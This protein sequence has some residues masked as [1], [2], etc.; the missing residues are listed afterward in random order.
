MKKLLKTFGYN[1]DMQYY[2]LIGD[3]FINGNF[4]SAIRLFTDMPKRNRIDM[5]KA[6]TVGG[7]ESGISNK[8]LAHL[9]DN[10]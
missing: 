5:L 9:F 8:H 6:A 2:E 1:S 7:W 3:N 4:T 10:L